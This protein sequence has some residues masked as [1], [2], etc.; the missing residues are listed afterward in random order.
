MDQLDIRDATVLGASFGGWVAAEV[1]VRSTQ[2]IARL[3]LVDPLGIKVGDRES[4]DIADMY[5]MSQA[6]LTA[7]AYHDPSR[8]TRDYST[9]SDRDLLGI[10]RSRES[11]TYF[12]WR[13]YM[14]DPSLRGWLQRIRVP[15][16]V[17]WGASDRIVTPDYGRAY[18]A[19]I[20]GARFELIEQAG[21]YPH[22]EQPDRFVELVLAFADANDTDHAPVAATAG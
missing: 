15:T 7:H 6:E 17:A 8:R 13:R 11:Y 4:R 19:E 1:A 20:P 2:R 14:H 3:V 21:H 12:G 16:L 5:A 18:A 22:V 9:M 10:A